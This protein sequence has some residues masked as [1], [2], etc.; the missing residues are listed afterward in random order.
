MYLVRHLR[1]CL[2]E[3]VPCQYN[4]HTFRKGGAG[5]QLIRLFQ[6]NERKTTRDIKRK[7]IFSI[8]LSSPTSSYHE[9]MHQTLKTFNENVNAFFPIEKIAISFSEINKYSSKNEYLAVNI[10][11]NKLSALPNYLEKLFFANKS[12]KNMNFIRI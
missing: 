6:A 5:G 9:L 8:K 10:R 4:L 7:D 3:K 1:I 12:P 2:S 11:K